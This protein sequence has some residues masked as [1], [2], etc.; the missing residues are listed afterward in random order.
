MV[1]RAGL[2]TAAVVWVQPVAQERLHVTGVPQKRE[3]AAGMRSFTFSPDP[4]N[5][6]YSS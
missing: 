1:V 2:V 5:S 3:R 4:L 6:D